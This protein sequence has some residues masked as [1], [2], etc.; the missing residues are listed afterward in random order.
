MA[1]SFRKMRAIATKP[2]TTIARRRAIHAFLERERRAWDPSMR[3]SKPRSVPGQI[4]R[5]KGDRA[6]VAGSDRGGPRCQRSSHR[7]AGR[8]GSRGVL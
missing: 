2:P 8:R 4:R 3:R 1:S 6:A 7:G 5:T